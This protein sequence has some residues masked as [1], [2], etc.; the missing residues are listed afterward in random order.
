MTSQAVLSICVRTMHLG[1]QAADSLS[2]NYVSTINAMVDK[3]VELYAGKGLTE[4]ERQKQYSFA[5]AV[6][7]LNCAVALQR[8]LDQINEDQI[9]N[10]IYLFSIGLSVISE[11]SV[12]AKFLADT[13]SPGEINLSEAAYKILAGKTEVFCRFTKQLSG[14]DG[15][16]GLNVYEAFWSP[17][18]VEVNQ[19]RIE[20]GSAID[21]HA[22]PA[23][24]FGI[25]L[26]IS[27]LVALCIIFALMAGYRPVLKLINQLFHGSF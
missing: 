21:P 18:E 26:I 12:L 22:Q 4:N 3:Q 6:L 24:S 23:R 27:I 20:G 15:F 13:A 14:N 25:K 11:N 2:V 1:D 8:Q 10:E 17:S 19:M 9:S 7:A 16:T 5:D